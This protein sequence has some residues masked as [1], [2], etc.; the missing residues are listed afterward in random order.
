MRICL[1]PH[2]WNSSC[3][4]FFSLFLYLWHIEVCCVVYGVGWGSHWVWAWFTA[5]V[6]TGVQAAL[7]HWMDSQ[8]WGASWV[9]IRVDSVEWTTRRVY[10]PQKDLFFPQRLEYY[11]PRMLPPP[12]RD[13]SLCSSQ[14]S[15]SFPPLLSQLWYSYWFLIIFILWK[16][17]T[18]I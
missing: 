18:F 9:F 10:F 14:P 1:T 2:Y 7:D 4:L 15:S 5:V 12:L 8:H 13:M 11:R 3:I 17:C 6:T 16:F